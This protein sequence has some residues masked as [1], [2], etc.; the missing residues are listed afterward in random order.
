MHVILSYNNGLFN[1]KSPNRIK[2]TIVNGI[3]V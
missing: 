3:D 1:K 2:Q